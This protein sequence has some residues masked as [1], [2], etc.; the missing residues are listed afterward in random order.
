MCGG[1][2]NVERGGMFMQPGATQ[3]E[4]GGHGTAMEA[5]NLM[6]DESLLDKV[7]INVSSTSGGV[8]SSDRF[9]RGSHPPLST[10][11]TPF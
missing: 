6:T 9:A 3:G 5:H 4:G 7:I 8:S 11:S 1:N 2:S 10:P